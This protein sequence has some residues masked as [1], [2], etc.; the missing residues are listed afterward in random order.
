MRSLGGARCR[1]VVSGLRA[2]AVAPVLCRRPVSWPSEAP[3]VPAGMEGACPRTCS[4]CPAGTPPPRVCPFLIRQP[5]SELPQ[6]LAPESSCT[7]RPAAEG[8]PGRGHRR[9]HHA[10]SKDMRPSLLCPVL[11][12]ELGREWMPSEASPLHAPGQLGQALQCP[13]GGSLGQRAG[14]RWGR[15]SS[16]AFVARIPHLPGDIFIVASKR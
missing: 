16:S 13:P 7:L 2:G 1:G 4:P 14:A 5:Q 15:L 8:M 10:A 6:V 12:G 3:L 9:R 11:G